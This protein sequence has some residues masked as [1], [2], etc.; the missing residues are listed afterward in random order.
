MHKEKLS[1]SF[2]SVLRASLRMTF[3]KKENREVDAWHRRA[4]L[5]AGRPLREWLWGVD[6]RRPAA[7]RRNRDPRG[8]SLKWY[9][10]GETV[11][12]LRLGAARLAQD[13]ILQKRKQRGGRL[14]QACWAI[15]RP[16]VAGVALGS[17]CAPACGRA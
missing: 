10:Q 1:G 14:A 17:R 16:S 8:N 11:W 13:D 4:G 15:G 7:G 3:F 5:L 6:V 9:A 12:V 2:D